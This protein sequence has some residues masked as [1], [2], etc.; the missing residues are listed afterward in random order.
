MDLTSE[1]QQAIAVSRARVRFA[2]PRW[3]RPFLMRDV[4]AIT[5]GRR[6]YVSAAVAEQSL[7][8]LLRHEIVHVSQVNRI[9]F[10]RFYFRYLAEYIRNRRSG[11]KS[12]AAYRNVSFE[13]EAFAAEEGEA[14]LDV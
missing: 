12:W 10:L 4:V 13:R 3:L 9:G 5:I 2:F 14:K 1:L 8:R 7:E 11:M 6:I